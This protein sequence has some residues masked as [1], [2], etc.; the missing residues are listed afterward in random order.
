MPCWSSNS[1][2]CAWSN[3]GH[4]GD[5]NLHYNVQAP[6]GADA[7]AFL[8]DQ[9]GPINALVYE[10]VDRFNGSI[11]AEHGIGSLKREKLAHHKSPVALNAMRAIKGALDPKNLMNPGR[12]LSIEV[13][14]RAYSTG[15]RGLFYIDSGQLLFIF[16]DPVVAHLILLAIVYLSFISLG[17]PDGIL[18]VAWPA[19]RAD[20]GQPLA[21]VG[22]I[23]ITMTICSATASFFAGPIAKR[24]G[25]GAVV[26]TSCL[27]TALAAAGLLGGPFFRL[28]GRTG[29]ATG[30][31]CGRC[32]RQ[33][34]PLCGGALLL[35]P[36]ELAA[37][38]LGRG[39]HHRSADHGPGTGQH[40]RL[41]AGC[42]QHWLDAT[43]SGCRALG[44]LVTL[45]Q[46]ALQTT[47]R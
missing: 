2:V 24:M 15:D 39:R 41:G 19:I 29:G 22:A 47:C 16:Q 25:A 45:G 7:E 38:F 26:A 44:D 37:R 1:P 12:V 33:L 6:D 27:M 8:R 40:R 11:S 46:R 28:A 35:P 23:A 5:G 14:A 18:G 9:E 3:Y 43:D 30:L 17:L 13:A 10:V 42:T 36:H 31:G 32:G 34:E 4:L 21:A 20:M